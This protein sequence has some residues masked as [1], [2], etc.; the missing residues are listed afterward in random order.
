MKKIGA[1]IIK[2]WILLKRDIA[3]IALLFLMPAMLIV[4]MALVQDA[5]FRDYQELR[6]DLLLVDNDGGSLAAEIKN[7]LRQSKNF[8]VV[9]S[10]EHKPL[11]ENTLRELLNKGDLPRGY[12]YS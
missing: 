11:D 2:E 1:T 3:G 6:F 5:P 4:V 8:H 7:G 12:S 10:F 9:D